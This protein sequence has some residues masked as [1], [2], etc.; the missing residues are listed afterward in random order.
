[1]LS[2]LSKP[3][4][5]RPRQLYQMLDLA[6]KVPSGMNSNT[7]AADRRDVCPPVEPCVCNKDMPGLVDG[8]PGVLPDTGSQGVEEV[9]TDS[10][11]I[12]RGA[13]G[14]CACNP[15]PPTRLEPP[16]HVSTGT[17]LP[18]Q[19]PLC[20]ASVTT[21]R[22]RRV[23]D[24]RLQILIMFRRYSRGVSQAEDSKNRVTYLIVTR[25]ILNTSSVLTVPFHRERV[26][27]RRRC[28][29]ISWT[30]TSHG[31]NRLIL[32]IATCG[33]TRVQL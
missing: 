15:P 10:K 5:M 16:W 11:G 23:H 14:C 3:H 29:I 12:S 32:H 31:L 18:F 9:R 6:Q 7:D 1:M 8:N 2:W 19:K 28:G 13:A 4:G 26:R 25:T 33:C 24:Q 17:S 27:D 21:W 30:F 20:R 22:R